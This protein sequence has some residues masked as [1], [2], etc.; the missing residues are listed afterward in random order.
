MSQDQDTDRELSGRTMLRYALVGIG[1]LCVAVVVRNGV[2]LFNQIR[3]PGGGH[4]V[5]A[6]WSNPH[7]VKRIKNPYGSGA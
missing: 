3:S 7:A 5:G 1:L 4:T 2:D 6:K